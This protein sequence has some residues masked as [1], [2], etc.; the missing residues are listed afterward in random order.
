MKKLTR[1]FALFLAA[2]FP[3]SLLTA[4]EMKIEYHVNKHLVQNGASELLVQGRK[5]R[6][7]LNLIPLGSFSAPSFNLFGGAKIV[8]IEKFTN[9]AALGRDAAVSVTFG[10]LSAELP[11]NVKKIKGL[12]AQYDVA[13]PPGFPGGEFIVS[14]DSLFDAAPTFKK[15]I[16]IAA[17]HSEEVVAQTI[18]IF[19][20]YKFFKHGGDLATL[21][22]RQ[23]HSL[24]HATPLLPE[25]AAIHQIQEKVAVVA[26]AIFIIVNALVVLESVED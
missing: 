1:S 22:I 3:C 5:T 7:A 24:A 10:G 19:I 12:Q 18:P 23:K 6:K 11:S 26:L 17:N 8:N 2:Y 14:L 15:K 16:H 13:V 20:P 21:A 25:H 4:E 9:G